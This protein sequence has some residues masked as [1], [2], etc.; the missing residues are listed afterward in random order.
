M[1]HLFFEHPT[2]L[3]FVGVQDSDYATRTPRKPFGM[4]SGGGGGV[5]AGGAGGLGGGLLPGDLAAAA[6][7]PSNLGKIGDSGTLFRSLTKPGF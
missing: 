3:N 7:T 5:L 4:S 2:L 1:Y 6:G